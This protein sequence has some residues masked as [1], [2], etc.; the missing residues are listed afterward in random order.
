MQG[1]VFIII[2]KILVFLAPLLAMYVARKIFPNQVEKKS[3]KSK[4]IRGNVVEGEV[5]QEKSSK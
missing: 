1:F 4:G 5:V 3:D 2:K